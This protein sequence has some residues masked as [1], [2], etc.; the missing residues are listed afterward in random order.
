[1]NFRPDPA[2]WENKKMTEPS[3]GG[4]FSLK[5]LDGL[6]LINMYRGY[7]VF[8]AHWIATNRLGKLEDALTLK[9]QEDWHEDYG[10]C[11][12]FRKNKGCFEPVYIGGCLDDDFP[13]AYAEFFI[14]VPIL[15]DEDL[16]K[17]KDE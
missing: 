13:K 15:F 6:N 10:D 4:D 8:Y 14:Q 2:E 16:V 11:I 17:V 7:D 5:T 12:W 9:K 1:M 3:V